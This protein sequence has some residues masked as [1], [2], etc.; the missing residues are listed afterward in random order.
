MVSLESKINGN[1]IKMSKSK[2]IADVSSEI[3]ENQ[4]IPIRIL[5]KRFCDQTNEMETKWKKRHEK[6]R[7]KI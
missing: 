3:H 7:G 1:W 2:I 5:F 6:I 4:P